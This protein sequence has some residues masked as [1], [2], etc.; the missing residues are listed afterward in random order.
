MKTNDF[1]S[2]KTRKLCLVMQANTKK[3]A[4][5][6]LAETAQTRCKHIHELNYMFKEHKTSR[7]VII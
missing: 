3:F 2:S 6:S 7:W 4:S 5:S 1:P